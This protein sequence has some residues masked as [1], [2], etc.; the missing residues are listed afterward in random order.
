MQLCLKKL[1]F[2]Q[3]GSRHLL[4][5]ESDPQDLGA[6]KGLYL[7]L[8][9][10]SSSMFAGVSAR[11]AGLM[12]LSALAGGEELPCSAQAEAHA[13]CIT[14]GSGRIDLAIDGPALFLRHADQLAD[15]AGQ[16]LRGN[17]AVPAGGVVAQLQQG[18]RQ[19]FL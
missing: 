17:E 6:M 10:E 5:E 8:A 13:A 4:F 11:S 2:G 7:S 12:R 1:P 3:C 18:R 15:G 9:S 14:A 16:L 19:N